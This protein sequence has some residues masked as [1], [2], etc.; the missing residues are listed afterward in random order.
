MRGLRGPFDLYDFLCIHLIKQ[1]SIKASIVFPVQKDLKFTNSKMSYSGGRTTWEVIT[2]P[3]WSVREGIVVPEVSTLLL[4]P[5]KF[6][7]WPN[8]RAPP[9]IEKLGEGEAL[10]TFFGYENWDTYLGDGFR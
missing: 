1:K 9:L 8:P 3:R 2:S 4:T 10:I 6:T 7:Q 5:T